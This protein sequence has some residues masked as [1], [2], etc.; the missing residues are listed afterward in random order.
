MKIEELPD[1]S[2]GHIFIV[3]QENTWNRTRHKNLRDAVKMAISL[4]KKDERS[5][6]FTEDGEFEIN[7]G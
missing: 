4:F 3:P 6:I 2:D 5:A 7:F 1:A